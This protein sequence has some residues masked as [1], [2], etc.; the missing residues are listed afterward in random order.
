MPNTTAPPTSWVIEVYL[1]DGVLVQNV[2]ITDPLSSSTN[3]TNLS[4]GTVYMVR[5]AGV[6]SQGIGNFSSFAIG[7][8]YGGTNIDKHYWVYF[9]N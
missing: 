6:N 3:L 4:R 7:E 8:T 5:V 9:K 1:L 2:T